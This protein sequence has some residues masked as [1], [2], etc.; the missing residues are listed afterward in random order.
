MARL[1]K[2]NGTYH[3]RVR[4][5]GHKTQCASFKRKADAEL[6]AADVERRLKLGTLIEDDIRLADLIERYGRE[7]S[8][9]KRSAYNEPY[10]LKVLLQSPIAQVMLRNLS[11]QH[12]AQFRDE[13]LT[14]VS[15]GTCRRDLNLLSHVLTIADREW[16]YTLITNPVSRIRKPPDSRPRDRRLRAG[17]E[18]RLLAA[19]RQ[20][21][22]PQWE[23]LVTLAIETGMR[24]GELLSLDWQYV[25]LERQ[26]LRLPMTKNGEMRDVPLS[27][28][29]ISVLAGLSP[30]ES[31]EVFLMDEWSH[32]RFWRQSMR[33]ANIVGLRFH[34]L[35]HEATSR[36][37]EKGLNVMEVATIT[38][39][40]EIRMLQR[41]THIGINIIS[42]KLG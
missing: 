14:Q 42:N 34:D 3:V 9:T 13:R 4:R 25:H 1:T 27:S 26:F 30:K 12:V 17:E 15:C 22:H 37:F 40:K 33:L 18:Q 29:A 24:R 2:I 7:V 23:P 31:G 20:I 32:A 8:P 21:I 41:Y 10:R 19:C 5:K 16:G 36:F 11:P 35:R 38:G 28:K 6:W 39:H